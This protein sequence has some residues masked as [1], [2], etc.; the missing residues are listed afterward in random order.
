MSN[1]Y[2]PQGSTPMEILTNYLTSVTISVID[3]FLLLLTAAIIFLV[4][5]FV[6]SVVKKF[7]SFILEGVRIKEW[8]QSVGLEKYIEDFTWEARFDQILAEIA[9]W[10]I[11][12]VFF[13]TA[14]D[15]LGLQVVNSFIQ[16]VINYLPRAISGGFVLALGF[17]LGELVRK[18]LVGVFRGLDKKTANGASL[19]VKWAIVVFA[20]LAALNQWGIAPDIINILAMGI[21]LFVALAGGLAFGLGGQDTAKEILESVVSKFK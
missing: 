18:F 15:I 2:L 16:N 9:F 13:M 21:V 20:F 5:F 4:G 14:M 12:V 19:F 6:A 11:M 10:V 1:I 7:L 3:K 8:L 17:I